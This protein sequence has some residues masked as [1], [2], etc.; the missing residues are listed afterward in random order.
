MLGGAD[1]PN[2]E[3]PSYITGADNV[4]LKDRATPSYTTIIITIC[5]ISLIP[6]SSATGVIFI[7]TYTGMQMPSSGQNPAMLHRVPAGPHS[8]RPQRL[9]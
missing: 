7:G 4:R 2:G 9:P 8:A 3:L 1:N 6:R 5:H